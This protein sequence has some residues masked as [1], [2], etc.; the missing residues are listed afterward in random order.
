[1]CGPWEEKP[2]PHRFRHTFARIL[3]E[4]GTP[5]PEVAAL[6]G[7]TE[8]VVAA[9]YA[10]WNQERNERVR[11]TVKQAFKSKAKLFAVK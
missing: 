11:N 1:M 9:C 10:T 8:E 5:I 4:N 2:E 6:L 3:L 7:D